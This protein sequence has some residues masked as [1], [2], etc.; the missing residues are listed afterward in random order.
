MYKLA[1]P[2][3]VGYKYTGFTDYR[4][5]FLGIVLQLRILIGL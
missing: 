4:L 2:V 3:A 5:K 1:E